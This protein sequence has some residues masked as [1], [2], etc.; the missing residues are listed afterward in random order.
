MKALFDQARKEKPIES[1]NTEED[2]SEIYDDEP[3]LEETNTSSGNTSP[4]IDEIEEK[5]KDVAINIIIR[6]LKECRLSLLKEGYYTIDKLLTNDMIE[7]IAEKHPSNV[8]ELKEIIGEDIEYYV[9]HKILE[10]I[11]YKDNQ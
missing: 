6:R 1:I 11:R 10:A 8:D 3:D 5:T 7:Q 9:C 4:E 2:E